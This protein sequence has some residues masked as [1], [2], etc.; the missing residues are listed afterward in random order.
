M[1]KRV[2]VV[3]EA[4]LVIRDEPEVPEDPHPEGLPFPRI[5]KGEED[6]VVDENGD[7]IKLEERDG[8]IM[9]DGV[10]EIGADKKTASDRAAEQLAA[11]QK[12]AF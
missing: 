11:E 7:W 6:K 8:W 10:E 3:S 9:A 1:G 5:N 4:G 2:R 12:L